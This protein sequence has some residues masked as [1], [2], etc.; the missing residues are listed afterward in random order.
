MA[1]YADTTDVAPRNA[2]RMT[3]R[4]QPRIKETIQRAAAIAG[5]DESTFTM[6]A[7]YQAAMRTIA[8]HERTALTSIDHEAFFAA[9][10]DPPPPSD[11]LRA[12]FRRHDETISSS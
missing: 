3:F 4:T 10:D 1:E 7:A 9:L 2:A 5:V 12:A 6:S 8:E 11:A